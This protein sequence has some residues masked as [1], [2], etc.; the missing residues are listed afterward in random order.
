MREKSFGKSF[1]QFVVDGGSGGRDTIAASVTTECT[2]EGT[3]RR[4]GVLSVQTVDDVE[5]VFEFFE[6]L[7]GLGQNSSGEGRAILHARRD[8]GS[9]IKPLILHEKDDPLGTSA[10]CFAGGCRGE[11][12]KEG[13]AD[14][15]CQ[16]LEDVSAIDHKKER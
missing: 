12:W 7:N 13:G 6:G 9:G 4:A 8:A 10:R 11:I 15:G 5:A 16:S 1:A 3:V 2:E 14:T